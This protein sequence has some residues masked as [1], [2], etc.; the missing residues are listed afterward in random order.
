M[1][2]TQRIQTS[3]HVM[4][5][6]ST[7][8]RPHRTYIRIRRPLRERE[9]I[10]AS[11]GV[12]GF[13]RLHSHNE[14]QR[15]HKP[16]IHH[17]SIQ[18]IN[19][20]KDC[21][22]HTNNSPLAPCHVCYKSPKMKQDLSNYTD[23]KSCHG[24][25]CYICVRSCEGGYCEGRTICSKCCVEEGEDGRVVCLSCLAVRDDMVMEC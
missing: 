17:E 2:S 13:F 14:S 12:P 10:S 1:P 8:S 24:R 23:C 5:T 7:D 3:I 18:T 15:T 9:S 19:V 21:S 25:A 22:T 4:E 6:H 20:H 16:D 11:N